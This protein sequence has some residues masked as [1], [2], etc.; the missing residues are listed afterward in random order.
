MSEPLPPNDYNR[1]AYPTMAHPQTF[2]DG[3][4]VK[5]ILRGMTPADPA[6][7]RVLELGCGDGF[8]LAAMAVLHP[9]AA[10]VGVDYAADAVAR[11]RAM[12]AE[13]GLGQVRLESGDI[14]HLDRLAELGEFDYIVAHGV[15]SWVPPDVRDALLAALAR[16]LAPQG[17]AFVSY[18]ALPGAYQREIART[19][20]RFHTRATPDPEEKILQARSLMD[21]VAKGS[22]VDNVYTRLIAAESELIRGHTGE[23][24]FHDELSDVSFPLLFTDFLAHAGRYGLE[25]LSEAEYA[26]PVA[27]YLSEVGREALRP[28]QSN[29]ILLEQYLDLMEGRRFRQT[30]LVRQGMPG[31]TDPGR[32]SA[33][34]INLRA[35]PVGPP[36]PLAGPEPDVYEGTGRGQA[37]ARTPL[38]K[39][40]MRALAAHPG[41]AQ[42]LAEILG[43]ARTS[44]AAEAVPPPADADD[45]AC[46]FLC[47]AY[48]PGLVEVRVGELPFTLDA[49]E[50]P[51]SHPLARY[52]LRR[53]AK[54]ILS[55][56]GRFVEVQGSLGRRLLELL[57]GTRDRA[58]LVAELRGFLA[59][60]HA[61]GAAA[62]LPPADDPTLPAQLERSLAGLAAMGFIA[63][64]GQSKA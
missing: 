47:R 51:V 39:A 25:F 44:L 3:L 4:A 55:Y 56:S 52:L 13:A 18:L 46:D 42:P 21:L 24:F 35:K 1:V 19:L 5:G 9:G 30:L 50:R 20:V 14:R 43:T 33:L 12:L 60:Q 22:T 41:R 17:V 40:V 64:D 54:S 6:R 11:G 37:Q 58:A 49:P 2:V 59:A 32:L 45:A 26:M 27:Q 31:P 10:Y 29:R 36:G 61:A 62:D 53:G 28:L 16:L 8:N 48:L 63:A 38:D 15:F 23:A 7:A 34:R 57:D